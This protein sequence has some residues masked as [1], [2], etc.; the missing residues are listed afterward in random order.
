M[1]SEKTLAVVGCTDE[2]T[3]HL[4]LLMRKGAHR[5]VHRWQ[6]GSE[7]EADF[8]VVDPDDIYG[9]VARV[10]ASARHMPFAIYCDDEHIGTD[11]LVLRRPLKLENVVDVLNAA[12]RTLDGESAGKPDDLLQYF[13]KLY[14]FEP[15]APEELKPATATTEILEIDMG[16]P[17]ADPW[18]HDEDVVQ[19]REPVV[20]TAPDE[21]AERVESLRAKSRP[22]AKHHVAIGMPADPI[23]IG[24][25]SLSAYV[26]KNL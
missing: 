21:A 24:S 19:P 8:V 26:T 3:A 22:G 17:G 9:A 20:A 14:R 4:R 25:F 16:S 11:Q 2:A 10:R 6:F 13:G 5:L 7:E 18:G 23:D 12:S 15:D 1:K